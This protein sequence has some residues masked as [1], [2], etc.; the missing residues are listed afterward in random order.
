MFETIRAMLARAATPTYDQ[1]V[2]QANREMHRFH[3][4]KYKN[5]SVAAKH[6]ANAQALLRQAAA[7]KEG[8]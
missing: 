8:R 2:N 4:G 5:F 3:L 1:L 7:M 6:R